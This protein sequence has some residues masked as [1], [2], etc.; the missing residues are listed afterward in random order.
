MTRAGHQLVCSLVLALFLLGAGL[1]SACGPTFDPY[2][3]LEEFR[4][5]AV[6]ISPPTLK[7]DESATAEV[8]FHLPDNT[9]ADS[10]EFKWE[11]CPISVSPGNRYK[12]P[13]DEIRRAG[14]SQG[15]GQAQMSFLEELDLGTGKSVEFNYPASEQVISQLCSQLQQRATEVAG[16][17]GSQVSLADCDRGYDVPIRVQATA[18]DKTITAKKKLQLYTGE[19]QINRNPD[20]TGI[21]IRPKSELS[22]PVTE[23]LGWPTSLNGDD[24]WYSPEGDFVKIVPG[25]PFDLLSR[26]SEDSVEQWR[27][28]APRGS[29][30]ELA[31]PERESIGFQWLA[32]GGDLREPSGLYD[33]ELNTL[34]KAGKSGI[35]FERKDDSDNVDDGEDNCPFFNNNEQTDSNDNGVGDA[36]EFEVWSVVKDGRRGVDVDRLKV[37]LVES[38][39]R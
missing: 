39:D 23:K 27:P 15:G 34:K 3:R 36:C 24:D 10:V 17:L 37:G 30:K 32:S 28:P 31:E 1:F 29:G 21:E 16:R 4:L 33:P 19:G 11:W 13:I 20:I 35:V 5:I 12:C 18:S 9:K 38:P 22:D 6:K 25:T 7:G 2:W 8:F 14:E 26:L